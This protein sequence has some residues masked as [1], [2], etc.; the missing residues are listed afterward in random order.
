MARNERIDI[1]DGWYLWHYTWFA[2]IWAGIVLVGG[3]GIIYSICSKA[4]ALAFYLFL[5]SH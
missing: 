2:M 3:L 1:N 4:E 5:Y